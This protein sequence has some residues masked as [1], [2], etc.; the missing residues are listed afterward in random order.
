MEIVPA[1]LTDNQQDFLRMFKEAEDFSEYIQIDVMDGEFVPS[2]SIQPKDL[3]GVKCRRFIE[4]HLMVKEPK[5]WLDVFY[6]L[7]AK[8]V[9]FHF[10]VEKD[11]KEIIDKIK[12]LNLEVGLAV[13]PH[14]EIK[15]FSH[16]VNSV[17]IVL[18]LSVIPGFYGSK[19]IPEVLNKIK[20][21]KKAHP[22]KP[23]GIDGGVKLSNIK[24]IS[25]TGVDFICVGSAVFN[26]ENPAKSYKEFLTFVK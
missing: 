22:G 16:L 15:D 9:I 5:R 25:Q 17:D 18:F 20:E 19:F 11:K 7:G 13:N 12:K 24:Q 2:K 4:A 26:S 21:F 1:I 8:R 10:E 23:V 3:A 14:T 6:K